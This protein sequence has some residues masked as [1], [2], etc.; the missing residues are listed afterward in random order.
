MKAFNLVSASVRYF[1]RTNLAV[2]LGVMTAISVLSGAWLVGDSVRVSLRDLFLARLGRATHVISASHYFGEDLSGRLEIHVGFRDTFAG[3]CPLILTQGVVTHQESRRRASE[4]QVYGVDQRFWQFHQQHTDV[5][6]TL[7][8][9]DCWVSESLAREAGIHEGDSI[10]LRLEAPSEIPAESVHGRKDGLGRTVRLTARKILPSAGLGEFS[11]SA[12]QGPVNVL[13]VPLRRLQRELERASQVN[14]LLIAEHG[15]RSDSKTASTISKLDAILKKTVTLEDMGVQLRLLPACDANPASGCLS[16]ER[17]STLLDDAV[18]SKAEAAGARVGLKPMPVLTY[19]AN[20]IRSQGRQ[21]PYSL[22]TA[23]DPK[24]FPMSQL[25]REPTDSKGTESS[26]PADSLPPIWL[27]RWAAEDLDVK[28]GSI[29]SLDYYIWRDKGRLDTQSA[30][31]RVQSILPMQG[32][33]ADRYLAPTYPGISDSDTLSDWDPPFPMDL[34]L[35]RPIDE[36]YWKQYRTTPKAFVPL[37]VG[38]KLWHSRFGSLTSLRL[39]PQS[40]TYGDIQEAE[41]AFRRDL[42]LQLSP[43]QMGFTLLPV[44]DQGLAASRGSMD[45]GEYFTYFSFFLVIAALLLTTLFFRLGIEQR[46]R[47]IGL[48]KSLGFGPKRIRNLFLQEGVLLSVVGSFLG[49]FGA[50]AYGHLMLYGLRHWWVGAVGTTHL[51]LHVSADSLAGGA[52]AGIAASL[53]C[54]VWTMHRLVPMSPRSLLSGQGFAN[55]FPLP[56][57]VFTGR[58]DDKVRR[59]ANFS[60]PGHSSLYLAAFSALLGIFVILPGTLHRIGQVGGFFG[61]GILFLGSLL[62]LQAFGLRRRF[63]VLVQGPGTA[64]ISALGIRN[65]AQ[66]R[67]RSLLCIALIASAAF[68]IVAVE[69]FRRD[70][71]SVPD[72]KQ[73]GTG[74]FLLFAQSLLPIFHDLNSSAGREALNLPAEDLALRE[75]RFARFRVR[76]GEDTSCLNL[77]Q[78]GNPRILA[79]T[80][81]F[82]KAGRFA[83][84]QSIAETET[85]RRNPWLLLQKRLPDGAIPVIGD[86]NSLAYVLHVKVGADWLLNRQNST[87]LRLRVVAALADSLFQRELLMSEENFKHL[88]PTQEGYRFFLIETPSSQAAALTQL[89]EDRLAD[90]GLDVSSAPERLATFHR[91]ENTYL[92]TFQ[93]LGGLGLLLGTLG[94]S[95]VLLRNVLERRREL[96]LLRAVGY[97]PRHLILMIVAENAFLLACGLATGTAC[98]L[99]AILPALSDRG[100]KLPAFSLGSSLLAILGTG[101]LASFVATRAAL[102]SSLLEALRA[103]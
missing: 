37:E 82:L 43:F 18:I 4:V 80:A 26:G 10:L 97:S 88:F 34:G 27:N 48:L 101:F 3:A 16:L 95:V 85:E 24:A 59:L 50:L 44:L 38:Q 71:S 33:G 54:I 92:S 47:E 58:P 31:F 30:D 23:I 69:S 96:A 63:P 5:S 56:G 2:A 94:L 64:S 72:N 25:P 51:S 45:F 21:I 66:R 29:V 78:P 17:S 55:S 13:F 86:A 19:L 6:N 93:A 67:G 41:Q 42:Q 49:I 14:T 103:E 15:S 11:L 8:Q 36:A 61:A 53:G 57:P 83:F 99:L 68:I 65:A 40:S 7:S 28:P 84:Q 9:R 89:L 98:A 100:W 87:P 91:V 81:D 32:L 70:P 73:S 1:W 35:I 75:S 52:L 46:F 76:P 60:P 90:Y 22:V 102:R 20:R 79:P 12:Q 39:L 74:G 77:F 62:F